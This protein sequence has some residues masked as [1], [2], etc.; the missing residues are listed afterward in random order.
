MDSPP[1][2][3]DMGA[4]LRARRDQTRQ[5]NLPAHPSPKRKPAPGGLLEPTYA[6]FLV[7]KP[8]APAPHQLHQ[9]QSKPSAGLAGLKKGFLSGSPVASKTKQLPPLVKPSSTKQDELRFNSVQDA[10]KS[11]EWLTPSFLHQLES[12]P[13]LAKLFTDPEFVMAAESMSK[14]PEA[15]IRQMSQKKPELLKGL[16]EFAQLLASHIDTT[17][18]K[19]VAEDEPLAPDEQRIIDRVM[20]DTVVQDA[21][22]DPRVQQV[23]LKIK[24]NPVEL[25]HAMTNAELRP[26]IQS[27]INA[28]LLSVVQ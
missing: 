8:I 14:N 25:S 26:K 20:K 3:E 24:E 15:T 16:Q 12:H 27:L 19:P 11:Q 28:G 4:V 6:P 5:A 13:R 2:L 22:K 7:D 17:F 18:V 1:E 23:L 9:N 10:M 21:L